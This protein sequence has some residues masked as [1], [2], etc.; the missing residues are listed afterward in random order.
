MS[1]DE[2]NSFYQKEYRQVYQGSEHPIQKDLSVQK[3]RSGFLIKVLQESG[4]E[5]IDR[6]LD[7]GCSSGILLER[8]GEEFQCQVVGI[9]PGD[10]YRSYA[11]SR[12]LKVYATLED[13]GHGNEIPFDL[14][15][16]IHVLEHLPD[17]VDYLNQL[18]TMWLTSTGLLLIEVPNLYAHDSFE[19][20]HLTSFSQFT[21][22]ETLK[23]AGYTIKGLLKHGLPRSNLIPLYITLL[24]IPSKNLHERI[25]RE[26]GIRMKRRAGIAQRRILERLLPKQA[27]LS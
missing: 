20:A 16:M 23:K 14:I 15:T 3:K 1:E 11:E 2:L 18:K 12:G 9:E 25:N 19:V 22:I 26:R 6:H 7:I 5:N 10:A 21:L 8:V 4:I 27:W 13:A 17:P 24:A